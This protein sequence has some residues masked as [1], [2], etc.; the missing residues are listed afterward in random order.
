MPPEIQD[1][2]INATGAGGVATVVLLAVHYGFLYLRREF[3][4]EKDRADRAEARADKYENLLLK[5]KNVVD[6][7]A[8]TTEELA[9]RM[10]E[11]VRNYEGGK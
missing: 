9:D 3:M 7:A 8:S 10:I 5:S 4:R 6:E 1:A 2:L 11:L